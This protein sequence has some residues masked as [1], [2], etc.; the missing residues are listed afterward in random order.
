MKGFVLLYRSVTRDE[1]WTSE[2]VVN[3]AMA[4]IDLL[5]LA[6]HNART[7]RLRN[8]KIHVEP[9][10]VPYSSR[11]LAKRW[12]TSRFFVDKFLKYL[13]QRGSV[14]V[15]PGKNTPVIRFVNWDKYQIQPHLKRLTLKSDHLKS[16][17]SRPPV[18]PKSQP[19]EGPV[20]Q[21]P[22]NLQYEPKTKENRA[23]TEN[24]QPPESRNPGRNQQC[25]NTINNYIKE[26]IQS[27]DES[28]LCALL[29]KKMTE[30]YAPRRIPQFNKWQK[31]ISY[32]LNE[33][34]PFEK[35]SRVI[36][37]SQNT[38]FWKS[39]IRSASSLNFNFET[40]AMQMTAAEKKNQNLQLNSPRILL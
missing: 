34:I 18:C 38:D 25:I 24:L 30:N 1:I 22:E 14:K 20:S 12:K 23:F 11:F 33:G 3:R 15:I 7:L 8:T 16:A 31:E 19:P 35:I 4:F 6:S 26:N 28:G 32:M 5:L 13:S 27:P 36:E 2:P 17:G 29:L 40:L 9:G 10:D 39:R 21:P 37:F